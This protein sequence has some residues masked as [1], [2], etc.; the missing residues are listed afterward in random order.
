MIMIGVS[1]MHAVKLLVACCY[2]KIMN[3]SG[4]MQSGVEVVDFE[5]VFIFY[6]NNNNSFNCLIPL[7]YLF[8]RK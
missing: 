6:N 2:N 3:D 4:M 7:L 1:G 8:I 5:V